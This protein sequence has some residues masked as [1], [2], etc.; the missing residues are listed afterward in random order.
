MSDVFN[1]ALIKGTST[2]RSNVQILMGDVKSRP[3]KKAILTIAKKNNIPKP[4]A[5]FRQ[6]VHIAEYYA[7]KSND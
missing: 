3:R 6:A 4:D 2:I 7:R 5:Q 1:P